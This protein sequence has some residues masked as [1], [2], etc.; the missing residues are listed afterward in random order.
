VTIDNAAPGAVDVTPCIQVFV[1]DDTGTVILWGCPVQTKNPVPAGKRVVLNALDFTTNDVVSFSGGFNQNFDS[2]IANV[3]NQDQGIAIAKK[4]LAKNFQACA[5]IIQCGLQCG[6]GL[7][8]SADPGACCFL[9]I[10]A[11]QPGA[12]CVAAA[13]ISPVNKEVGSGLPFFSWTPARDTLNANAAITYTLE[14]MEGTPDSEPKQRADIPAGAAS[15]QWNAVSYA[16]QCGVKYYWRVISRENGTPFCGTQGQGSSA[17]NWFT[18]SCKKCGP[19]TPGEADGIARDKAKGA[20]S[21]TELESVLSALKPVS[22][23]LTEGGN[24]DDLLC[25][26]RDGKA[27]IES[28]ELIKR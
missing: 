13:P 17:I 6:S 2:D 27:R 3:K 22:C 23:R 8:V 16:L 24:A 18:L 25:R 14:L 11:G 20:G 9:T 15:L 19:F 1:K 5:Q 12:H 26:L 4:Y 7:A 10:M 28:Y 21:S